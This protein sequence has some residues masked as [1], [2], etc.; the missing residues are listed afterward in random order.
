MT[1]ILGQQTRGDD[2]GQWPALDLGGGLDPDGGNRYKKDNVHLV[3][4]AFADQ[5][6]LPFLTPQLPARGG[7]KL[8]ALPLVPLEFL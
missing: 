2:A 6:R 1:L 4:I 7:T 8:A 5:H 3:L